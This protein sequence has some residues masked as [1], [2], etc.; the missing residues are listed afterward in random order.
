MSAAHRPR[1]PLNLF[2]FSDNDICPASTV[3]D[4]GVILDQKLSLENHV[5]NIC[6]SCFFY[7]HNIWKIRKYIS[8]EACETLVHAF[9]SSRLDFCN[10]LL[11]GLPKSLLQKLQHV[12]NAAA[13]V[14]SC[15][16]KHDHITPVLY[17]LHW[18][19]V[20]QRIEFKILLL[21]FKALNNAAPLY[22]CELVEPYVPSRSLRSSS[23]NL[24]T[25]GSFKLKTYGRRAFSNAA[26]ELWNSLPTNI[27]L[28]NT[29]S[30]FKRELKT[31][32]FKRAY[33]K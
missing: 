8:L 23:L 13:R 15:C 10:S 16:Q 6:K 20:E 26:P 19:P 1:P 31:W 24:L 18:L 4:I 22:L 12:Q 2:T 11:Y 14:V 32:L 27:R 5:I 9:I 7:I 30:S 21:T 17:S 3:R 25:K 28:C 29:V 33:N